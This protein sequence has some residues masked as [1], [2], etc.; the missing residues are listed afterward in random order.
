VGVVC[1]EGSEAGVDGG[2][3]LH[4]RDGVSQRV[5]PTH[6]SNARLT[7]VRG[8]L[9][10]CLGCCCETGR[11][12]CVAAAHTMPL[13]P[14]PHALESEAALAEPV[15]VVV[16]LTLIDLEYEAPPAQRT[17]DP[18]ACGVAAR[19]SVS[20]R[21]GAGLSDSASVLDGCRDASWAP[22][23][24]VFIP[25]HAA[26]C[27]ALQAS[28]P[29]R[30]VPL[31]G[32]RSCLAP[33]CRSLWR[34]VRCFGVFFGRQKSQLLLDPSRFAARGPTLD[35][36]PHL[37]FRRSLPPPRPSCSTGYALDDCYVELHRRICEQR[38]LSCRTDA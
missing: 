17:A 4:A 36:D 38:S 20:R 24:Q 18:S 27:R 3:S 9:R 16:V 5:P 14:W 30:L 37:A 10:L 26:M 28:R 22:S 6:H 35:R 2:T 11:A 31:S 34:A 19:H 1:E 12:K 33:V 21:T 8:R 23:G 13:L 29:L 15:D 25:L 32:P 7:A